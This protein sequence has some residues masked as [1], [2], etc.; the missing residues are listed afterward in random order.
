MIRSGRLLTAAV[1]VGVLTA[2]TQSTTALASHS[3]HSPEA[4]YA[5]GMAS[6]AARGQ[7]VLFGGYG[8]NGPH[9]GW[10]LHD[11]WTWNGI[12]WTKQIPVHL[13]S[14]RYDMGMAYDATNGQI[15]LF[16][17][18]GG[19]LLGDTWTWNG[20]DWT[21]HTPVHSPSP[22]YGMGMAYDA[23]QGRVVLFGGYGDR[24]GGAGLGFLGD[25]WTW[26]GTDWTQHTPAHS[27]DARLDMGMASDADQG[28]VVLFGGYGYCCGGS[29]P[30]WLG[31]TWTWSGTD[32]TQHTPAHSPE[33]RQ[34]MGMAYDAAQG[35]VILSGGGLGGGSFRDTWTWNGTDWTKRTPAHSPTFRSW[36]GM[37]FDAGHGEVLLFGGDCGTSCGD[38]WI[39]DGTDWTPRPAGSI[40]LFSRSGPPGG[41]VVLV[42]WGFLAGERV[43]LFLV[44]SSQGRVLLTKAQASAGGSFGLVVTIPDSATPG[45]QRITAVGANSGQRARFGSPSHDVPSPEAAPSATHGRSRTA[46]G[47]HR[48][49]ERR[50]RTGIG[51][52][53]LLV[54]GHEQYQ[55]R[56]RW[57]PGGPAAHAGESADPPDGGASTRSTSRNPTRPSRCGAAPRRRWP[58]RRR[59]RRG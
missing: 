18:R 47:H 23:A 29:G 31:E 51:E 19:L 24:G 14:P 9:R 45:A 27:P 32:W 3:V 7:V 49:R 42:G 58:A 46:R 52:P 5:M 33:A 25:T 17:G 54:G 43:K 21:K 34:G 2:L 11:T 59:G 50:E 57:G 20:I 26:S 16:G 15:V 12:D 13:P 37:A 39:W 8:T 10:L 28:Q 44:D 48:N 30:R 53:L 1:V 35:L 55:R 40:S 38:T 56:L 36:M 4:R 6:D 41:S 22:R